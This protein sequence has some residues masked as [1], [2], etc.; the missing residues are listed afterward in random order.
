MYGDLDIIR[1]DSFTLPSS[2][3]RGLLNER[4]KSNRCPYSCKLY[5]M[6]DIFD[7]VG[8]KHPAHCY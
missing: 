8:Y 7:V 4:L 5:M 3:R 1:D 2:N 6:A